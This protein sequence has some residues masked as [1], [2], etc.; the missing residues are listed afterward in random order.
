MISSADFDRLCSGDFVQ[1]TLILGPTIQGY[2]ARDP[3][4]DQLLRVDGFALEDDGS[5]SQLSVRIER[6][7][8]ETADILPNAPEVIDSRG[9]IH[10]MQS[11]FWDNTEKGNATDI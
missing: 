3:D 4:H 11:A 5:V 2:A 10:R 7:Q 6:S 8:I 9:I 1:L